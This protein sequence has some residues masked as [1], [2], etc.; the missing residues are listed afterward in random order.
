MA[1]LQPDSTEAKREN[2]QGQGSI[3]PLVSPEKNRQ[4]DPLPRPELSVPL[5]KHNAKEE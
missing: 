4:V 5:C 3:G 1:Y 2:S